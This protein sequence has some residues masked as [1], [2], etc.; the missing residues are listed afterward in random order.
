MV[1]LETIN[2]ANV[3]EQLGNIIQCEKNCLEW[4]CEK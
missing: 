1:K 4:N 2:Y 3:K